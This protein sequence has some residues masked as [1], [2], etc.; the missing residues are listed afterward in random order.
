MKRVGTV[1]KVKGA[2]SSNFVDN[3]KDDNSHE[4]DQLDGGQGFI[5]EL[6]DHGNPSHL[7]DA[8]TREAL[9][10]MP[11]APT[12]FISKQGALSTTDIAAVPCDTGQNNANPFSTARSSL[13]D[14]F[15]SSIG[16]IGTID[17]E[18]NQANNSFGQL[19]EGVSTSDVRSN[20][21]DTLVTSLVDN[22]KMQQL[23]MLS[24]SGIPEQKLPSSSPQQQQLQHQRLSP[25]GPGDGIDFL[26]QQLAMGTGSRLVQSLAEMVKRSNGT[27]ANTAISAQ[28][29]GDSGA[30]SAAQCQST[31]ASRSE[32]RSKDSLPNIDDI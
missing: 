20:S 8:T 3:A 13:S 25:L 16:S 12:G 21:F 31:Q 7:R 2:R 5:Q 15:T 29:T 32:G 1:K 27:A 26:Q 4:Y 24:P 11:S 19:F 14:T 22:K 18:P 10:T 30:F 6:E 28:V 23:L 9:A 17:V